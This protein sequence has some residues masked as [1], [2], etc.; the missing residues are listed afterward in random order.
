MG[1]LNLSLCLLHLCA[2]RSHL[3]FF[4]SQGEKYDPKTLRPL[5]L[6]NGKI[7]GKENRRRKSRDSDSESGESSSSAGVSDIEN[8]DYSFNGAFPL[9]SLLRSP[10]LRH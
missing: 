4:A 9:I 8:K 2:S 6:Q 1:K 10:S 5:R 7:K 3:R